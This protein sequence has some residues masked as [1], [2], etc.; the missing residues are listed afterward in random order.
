MMAARDAMA[1]VRD[2]SAGLAAVTPEVAA[3]FGFRLPPG[4]STPSIVQ[5]YR[6]M[7]RPLPLLDECAQRYGEMFTLRLLGSPPWIF[8]W[9]PPLLKTMFTAPSDVAHAGE[10][11]LSVFG[12]IAGEA[13]VFTMDE[14]AHLNR[15]RLLLPQFH[16]DRMQ[17]YFDQIRDIASRAIDGW[18]A[19]VPFAMNRQTQQM[20]LHAIIRAVF[21]IQVNEGDAA[22]RALVRALTDLA[23]DGVGSPLLLARPLQR[24][25]GAWSPWGRVLRIIHRADEAIYR[26]IARRRAAADVAARQDIL[27]L[28]LQVRYDDGAPLTDRE[29][30]DELVVM[31]MAGHETTGTALAWA[32]E[33]ILSLPE[34]ERRLRDELTAVVGRGPL[35]AAHLPQL[36]YLDAVVKE[37]LRNRPIMPAG[38]ARLLRQALAIGDYVVPAGAILVNAMYLLHRRPELYPDPDAFKPERF[39]GR[40]SID[41]YEWT[42][43]GGGMRRCLGHAFALFEMK[44]IL[45]SVLSRVRLRIENP[46]AGV[47]RRGFFLAPALGPRV[48]R[49]S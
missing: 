26:E 19:D 10:A 44:T 11:N 46:G 21:G 9:S 35:E 40:R 33:R 28:L 6:Y 38:G 41:P 15:R 47:V 3:A 5:T 7:R 25:W 27:S 22:D 12:A 13:S 37:S 34:V 43:F 1:T 49:L 48:T 16:G 8:V 42:P 20:T 39:V 23:N 14:S 17:V 31:L 36:E 30:R 24:D 2:S 29:V 4:P 18:R 32:F 45:A